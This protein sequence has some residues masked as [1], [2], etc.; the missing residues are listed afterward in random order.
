MCLTTIKKNPYKYAKEDILC[1]KVVSKFTTAF[2]TDG[3]K[4]TDGYV[5][6]YQKVLIP[7]D[8]IDGKVPF[9]AQ[10]K[11]Q[12]RSSGIEKY[13]YEGYIHVFKSYQDALVD[14][15]R[16]EHEIFQC[17]IPKGTRYAEG[18]F[19]YKYNCYAAKQIEF[20]MPMVKCVFPAK[21]ILA[22]EN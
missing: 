19:N 7:Q 5:T 11:C 22:Y 12:S 8:V 21:K 15:C 2:D 14:G 6:P 13:I 9:K 17:I 10:G 20:I 1:Y 16:A 3:R 18:V 4:Y